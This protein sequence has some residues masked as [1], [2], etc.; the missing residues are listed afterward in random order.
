MRRIS[1]KLLLWIGATAVVLF[2]VA[3]LITNQI[4]Q[5]M[6]DDAIVGYIEQ[7]EKSFYD[8]L[9]AKLDS[10]VAAATATSA[11]AKIRVA[12]KTE[13]Y[14]GLRGNL[15]QISKDFAQNTRFKIF[16]F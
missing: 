7:Q 10:G 2:I 6:L 4:K 13:D 9:N 11:D 8:L 15:A 5:G 14:D 3:L 12:I 16:N 1:S